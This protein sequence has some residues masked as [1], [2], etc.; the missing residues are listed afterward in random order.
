MQHGTRHNERV[1]AHQLAFWKKEGSKVATPAEV[2][3]FIADVNALAEENRRLENPMYEFIT[4]PVEQLPPAFIGFRVVDGAT[5]Q[6][7][8]SCIRVGRSAPH[9]NARTVLSTLSM[10]NCFARVLGRNVVADWS[11]DPIERFESGDTS[12]GILDIVVTGG[13]ANVASLHDTDGA[14]TPS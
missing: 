6:S 4:R 12:E 9:A 7:I 8:G 3:T 5:G 13:V 14:V 10:R 1:E 11:E 2:A